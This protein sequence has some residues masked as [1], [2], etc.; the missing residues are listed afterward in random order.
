MKRFLNFIKKLI[1]NF[2]SLFKK[3]KSNDINLSIPYAYYSYTEKKGGDI[4]PGPIPVPTSDTLKYYLFTALDGKNILVTT[5]TT[6][7]FFFIPFNYDKYVILFKDQ[8][9]KDISP[10]DVVKEIHE[11]EYWNH[12]ED[13]RPITGYDTV[14]LYNETTGEN[15]LSLEVGDNDFQILKYI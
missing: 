8:K 14:T 11:A 4:L 2:I 9:Y 12:R 1:S 10:E 7:F 3:K 5:I 15:R 13:L 6:Y